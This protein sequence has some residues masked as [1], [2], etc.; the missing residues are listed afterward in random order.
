[1]R[2]GCSASNVANCSAMT[3]GAWLGNMT[4]PAPT[5]SVVVASARWPMST[6]GAELATAGIPWCSATHIRR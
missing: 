4:P 1:M 6:A 2:P 3:N 5:R